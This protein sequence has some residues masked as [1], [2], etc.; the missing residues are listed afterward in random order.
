MAL[1]VPLESLQR[2]PPQYVSPSESSL[3]LWNLLKGSALQSQAS[4]CQYLFALFDPCSSKCCA[5]WRTWAIAW[6]RNSFAF[7]YVSDFDPLAD[8]RSHR[9]VYRPLLSTFCSYPQSIPLRY[10]QAFWRFVDFPASSSLTHGQLGALNVSSGAQDPQ[11]LP[12][13]GQLAFYSALLSRCAL[14]KAAWYHSENVPESSVE[15]SRCI[16]AN[17]RTLIRWSPWSSLAQNT[18]QAAPRELLCALFQASML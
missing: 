9:C 4:C 10:W 11:F 6:N 16:Q 5:P 18:Y 3:K 7:F 14:F 1:E 15:F 12:E 2:C 17:N 8:C 13:A